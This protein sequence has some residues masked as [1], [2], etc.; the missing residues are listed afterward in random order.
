MAYP[1]DLLRL[2]RIVV[3]MEPSSQAN[4][5]RAVSTA[6]YAVFHLLI[7]EATAN[8]ANVDARSALGRAFD[9]GTMK[10]ASDRIA[11]S[12]L[13]PYIGED[14]QIVASLRRVGLTFFRLQERRHFADYN[15]A[16]DLDRIVA[17]NQ[18]AWAEEVFAL[19][20]SISR[21]Q[22]TQDYL[23]SLFVKTR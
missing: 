7:S 5:R 2:A 18:V 9:H 13:F 8:W 22:I 14:P 10:A 1:D 20:P 23:V 19:W 15:F 4:R 17:V 3:G 6:Y 11:R 12:E 21:A 16:K